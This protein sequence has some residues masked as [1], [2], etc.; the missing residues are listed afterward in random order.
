MQSDKKLTDFDILNDSLLV[1][2]MKEWKHDWCFFN[3]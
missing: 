1:M 2:E 3:K